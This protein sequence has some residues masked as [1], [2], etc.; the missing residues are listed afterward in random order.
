METLLEYYEYFMIVV[1]ILLFI[2]S[3]YT[4]GRLRYISKY[5]SNSRFRI[6]N[7][8]DV[9]PIDLTENFVV[10]VFNNNINDAR[11][12]SIGLVYKNMNIDYFSS[13]IDQNDLGADSKIMIPSRDSITLRIRTEELKKIIRNMNQG[14][15]KVKTI[16]TFVIDSLGITTEIKASQIKKNTSKLIK[17]E[18]KTEKA[19]RKAEIK[20]IKADKKQIKKTNRAVKSTKRREKWSDFSIRVKSKFRRT[21]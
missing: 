5:F 11:V 6:A 16:K 9:N 20:N 1:V 8:Y 18:I 13:Y 21:K 10:T 2:L 7:M 14:K 12:V 3:I 15:S 19:D 4:L 17:K